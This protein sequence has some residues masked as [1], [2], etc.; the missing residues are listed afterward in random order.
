LSDQ[1]PDPFDQDEVSRGNEVFAARMAAIS[2]VS[3]ENPY[4]GSVS[5]FAGLGYTTTIAKYRALKSKPSGSTITSGSQKRRAMR[6]LN[7]AKGEC[8]YL[9]MQPFKVGEKVVSKVLP[10]ALR[11]EFVEYVAVKSAIDSGATISIASMDTHL[12]DFCASKSI[13]IRAFNNAVTRSKGSGTMYGVA[14]DNEGRDVVLT[15]SNSHQVQGATSDLISADAMIS[16]GYKFVLDINGSFLITP[17][18]E[19][20]HL[21]RKSGLFWLKW[22]KAVPKAAANSAKHRKRVG[23]VAGVQ[24][25]DADISN[26]ASGG[27]CDDS[28]AVAGGDSSKEFPHRRAAAID[29]ASGDL[30]ASDSAGDATTR[31]EVTAASGRAVLSLF[32]DAERDHEEHV[33]SLFGCDYDSDESDEGECFLDARTPVQVQ[34]NLF[35]LKIDHNHCFDTGSANSDCDLCV[36][37]SEECDEESVSK[38]TVE[39]EDCDLRCCFCEISGTNRVGG[40]VVQDCA[41]GSKCSYPSLC[42]KDSEVKSACY[43][44]AA[45]VAAKK[46]KV[47]LELMHRRLGHFNSGYLRTMEAQ[48]RLDVELIGKHTDVHCDACKRSKATRHNPPSQ[49]ESDPTPTKPFEY[50]YSDVKGKMKADFFGNRYMVVFACEVTRWTAVYFC[51]KKSQVVDRFGDFLKWVKLHGYSVRL[52]TTDGAGEYTAGENCTNP[53]KFQ[54]VCQRENIEQRFSAANTQAQNGIS[55][56]LMRTLT[57]AAAAMLHDAVLNHSWW[58][59]AIKHVVW[60]RN[61]VSHASLKSGKIFMSPFEKLHNRCAKLSMV[62]V[63]G[64]DAWR[65]NF[66]RQKATITE[67]KGIKGIF[68]GISPDRKG[69]MIFDPK[70][71]SIRTSYHCSFSENFSHRRDSLTGFKLRVANSKLSS[72]REKELMEVAELF[73]LD[74]DEFLLPSDPDYGGGAGPKKVVDELSGV[75]NKSQEGSSSMD[76]SADPVGASGGKDLD[77]GVSNSEDE[78]PLLR[79]SSRRRS[80]PAQAEVGSE[81]DINRQRQLVDIE[82]LDENGNLVKV[83]DM[84]PA[85]FPPGSVGVLSADHLRFLKFAFNHDWRMSMFQTNPKRGKSK[86]RYDLYKGTTT[87]R[88][89]MRCGGSWKDVENDYARGFIVFDTSSPATVREVKERKASAEARVGYAASLAKVSAAMTYDDVVRREFGLIGAE[90]LEGLSHSSQEVIKSV[91][92]NQSL[93]EFAFCCAARIL[94][95]EP[96]TVTEALLSEYAAEW[97]AAMDEEMDTLIKFGCFVRVKRADA[98]QHGRLVKSKWVFKVK[99]NAD[100][101][102]QRFKARL[103]GKGFTQVPGTDFYETYSP[104]FSYTSLR[105]VLA[106]AAAKDLQIDQWDLKSSFIQQD[107]DVDHLYLETPEGYS[108]FLEDGVTPAALHLKKSLYGLVQSSRLLHKRLSKFLKSKGFRQLVSD[109]CVFVKGTGDDEVIVCTWVDDIIMASKRSNDQARQLFDVDIRTEFT[110]SPWTAG[111]AGWLLN[112]KVVRDWEAG[113]LHVSQ[114]AAIEKLA[115]RFKLNGSTSARPYVPMASGTKLQK[116]AA[117]DVVKKD[118]FDYM[119]AVGGLLYIALTTR[120]DVSYAVGVLSRYMA[121]PGEEHVSAAKRVIQYLFRTKEYGIMYSRDPPGVSRDAPHSS[122]APVV[123]ARYEEGKG[124]QKSVVVNA[125]GSGTDRADA[126]MA[127]TYVDA[128]LAGDADTM[129]STTG[130][131]IMLSGGIVSW[132]S[133]LQTTVALSTTEA[134][135]NAA[136]ELVKQIC[137]LRLFLRELNCRQQFPTIVYEDNIGAMA[138]VDGS[139]SSKKAKHYLMKVHYLREQADDGLF[140]MRKVATKD[141]LADVFTKPLPDEIFCKFRDWMGVLPPQK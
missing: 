92:G 6:L 132:L 103:V 113:T 36:Q 4:V 83:R 62:R 127:V 65:F 58:S 126:D 98:L 105:T 135:S 136:C 96:V 23:R 39:L 67:P 125:S 80:R 75:R 100:G 47:H 34:E 43:C 71:R 115:Q 107:I 81:G 44:G 54:R 140:V 128:D 129:R 18:L 77:E 7:T 69:W 50:V 63:F 85:P 32:E 124:V 38:A 138:N 5:P 72:A 134:E 35:E 131:A 33:Q 19:F 104:V 3:K 84:I 64:C 93:S 66:D 89:F 110:V 24:S 117:S 10:E 20:I 48:Q 16:Q 56:R 86:K 49:R 101:S 97:R 112:M 1:S 79:R 95:P 130:F 139:E 118:V 94:I 91:I 108:K 76:L 55:E 106:R 13:Q 41:L 133:K 31:A 25:C 45:V 51:R 8:M 119:S 109:Q 14:V 123:F 87:L 26:D 88:E 102:L 17:S 99:Y 15:V 70:S 12:A 114:E 29:E 9:A 27:S 120:P 37:L 116:P 57:D 74:R 137:Y 73:S 111:E 53:S 42:R 22:Y 40:S 78:E 30:G 61:R 122:D 90:Y 59:L 28:F 11:D 141:Q 60:I 2:N 52:I 82:E 21:E 46:K 68:V 121:C